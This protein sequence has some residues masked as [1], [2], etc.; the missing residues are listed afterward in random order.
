V[1]LSEE[2]ASLQSS[3]VAELQVE[4]DKLQS[5]LKTHHPEQCQQ[6]IGNKNIFL[7]PDGYPVEW[8]RVTGCAAATH[9]IDKEAHAVELAK[10]CRELV[11]D[12]NDNNLLGPAFVHRPG[13]DFAAAI[14]ET[15]VSGQVR[16]LLDLL[17]ERGADSCTLVFVETRYCANTVL[18][19]LQSK[20][21]ALNCKHVVGQSGDGGMLWK[22]QEKVLVDFR[23]GDCK[24]VVCTTVLE[25]GMQF[26][27]LLLN[28]L[29][30]FYDVFVSIFE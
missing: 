20:Y 4:V 12:L 6:L 17:T 10:K 30:Y 27:F 21:P 19:F 7:S 3:L 11:H 9:Y 22:Q 2:Q 26:F 24:L 28:A 18:A 8:K 16:A 14:D 23:K 5:F 1:Q 29:P 25:E 15:R 13:A